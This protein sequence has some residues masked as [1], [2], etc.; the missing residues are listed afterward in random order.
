MNRPVRNKLVGLRWLKQTPQA[1]NSPAPLP[2]FRLQLHRLAVNRPVRNKLVGLGWLK[3]T[4]QAPNS[5][6]LVV[7]VVVV[8]VVDAIVSTSR[9]VVGAVLANKSKYTKY[10]REKIEREPGM[11]PRVM[12]PRKAR[13][14]LDET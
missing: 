6:A 7:V 10:A 4:P 8:V 3:Q 5:P 14:T 11:K 12:S 1:P 2:Y 9:H 13:E